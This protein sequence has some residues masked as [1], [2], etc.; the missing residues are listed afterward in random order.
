MNKDTYIKVNISTKLKK[1]VQSVA[2]SKGLSVSDFVRYQVT[3]GIEDQRTSYLN[4]LVSKALKEYK[5]GKLPTLK[6]DQDIEKEFAE[7]AKD[8]RK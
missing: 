6:T 4:D 1:Q 8:A 2:E 7:M 5:A 3:K